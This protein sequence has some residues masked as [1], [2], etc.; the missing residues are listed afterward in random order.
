M[1]TDSCHFPC[2]SETL[3]RPQNSLA[4]KALSAARGLARGGLGTRQ[5]ISPKLPALFQ[6]KIRSQVRRE[7]PQEN[8]RRAGKVTFILVQPWGGGDQVM[9]H[10]KREYEE[11]TAARQ[12]EHTHTLYL[13]QW[14]ALA[15]GTRRRKRW[16]LYWIF[17]RLQ[18]HWQGLAHERAL[19]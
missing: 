17:R 10:E 4:R 13:R 8:C 19:V 6:C 2:T 3:V 12:G 9:T 14:A 18:E 1:P 16:T 15:M 7:N 5:K 11:I